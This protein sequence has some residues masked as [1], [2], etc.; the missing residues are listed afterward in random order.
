M[1]ATAL[2]LHIIAASVWIGGHL[3]L[4]LL[5]LPQAFKQ[6]SV[7]ELLAFEAKYEKIGMPALIIQVLS[8]L[9]LAWHLLPDL[10]LWWPLTTPMAKLIAIKLS[11]LGATLIFAL[12]ARLRVIPNLSVASLLDLSLHIIPVTMISIAFAATGLSLRLGWLV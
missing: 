7:S 6:Q 10:A 5:I 1:F 12:D 3:I 8:G 4:S 9:Y 2:L 11:L